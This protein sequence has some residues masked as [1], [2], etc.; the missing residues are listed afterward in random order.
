MKIL[1]CDDEQP[2]LDLL[3]LIL[4][5]ESLG[6]TEILTAT[7]GKDALDIVT[8]ESPDILIT[9][10]VMPVM[11]GLELTRC[12]RLLNPDIPILIMSAFN[13]FEYAQQA[14]RYEVRGYLL[15]PLDEYKLEELVRDSVKLIHSRKSQSDRILTTKG[16][17]RER[18]LRQLLYPRKNLEEYRQLLDTLEMNVSLS[19]FNLLLVAVQQQNY[20][21]YLNAAEEERSAPTIRILQDFWNN[22]L[23]QAWIFENSPREYVI[24]FSN[25]GCSGIKP[26]MELF[27]RRIK[28]RIRDPFVIAVS[29]E[30]HAL[31][32]LPRA[33][34]EASKYVEEQFLFNSQ[35]LSAELFDQPPEQDFSLEHRDRSSHI[36]K[37]KEYISSRY[38]EN[39][40][41]DAICQH[42]G[43]SKNYFCHLFKG[44]TG[45]SIW[46]YLTN[47]RIEKAK[48][49]LA[50]SDL[51]NYEVS[52]KIGYENPSYFSRTFKK[53]TGLSP[54]EFRRQLKKM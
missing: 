7:N 23:N 13:E 4:D 49:F 3:Q 38:N 11:D 21:D 12:V 26:A 37:A 22:Q 10:I 53:I 50:G 52:Y 2:T 24:I 40:S 25:E 48:E 18:L 32:D 27:H 47:F 44:E 29:R 16:I 31:R 8:K 28:V 1:L 42:A 41:L 30:Y 14:I 51:K 17:A 45:L 6:I 15:K 19:A 54:T 43:V 34:A 36:R 20:N 33:Y 39:I 9:D 35:I 5:W 46:D